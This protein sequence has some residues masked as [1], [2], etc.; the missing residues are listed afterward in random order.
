MK[1]IILLTIITIIG[2][3]PVFAQTGMITGKIT[4]NRNSEPIPF[5]SV[6]IMDTQIGVSADA[7]GR[8]TLKE[9]PAGRQSLSVS[10]LG[11]KIYNAE[12]D[13][14]S[15]GEINMEVTL[16]E[17]HHHLDEVVVTGTRTSTS[18]L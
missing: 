11:F 9:V 14:P 4:S 16:R 3:S 15:G 2:C 18:V 7:N 12:V 17:E 5:A 6:Q 10:S 1:R 13:V 8:F